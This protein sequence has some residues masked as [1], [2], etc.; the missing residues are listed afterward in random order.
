MASFKAANITT[1]ASMAG[2]KIGSWLG[3]NEPE[4]FAALTK[5]GARPDQGEHHQ[6]ELRHVGAAQGRPR[7]GPGD[8][9]QRVRAGPR[10]QEPGHRPALHSPTTST[11][12]TSTTRRSGPRCSR[13]RSSPPTSGSRPATT[14]T[15]PTKFL[16][17]LVQ[18]LDL[19]PRQRPEVRRH[20]PRQGLA[21]GRQPPGVADERDQRADLAVADRH[22][23]ARQGA[24]RPDDHDRHDVQGPQGG[25]VGRRDPDRPRRRRRSTRSAPR[26]TPRAR[27]SP[28]ARSRSRRAATSR[29]R[30][31]R[32]P[33]R[34]GRPLRFGRGAAD[35]VPSCPR[36]SV[37]RAGGHRSVVPADIGSSCPRTPVR[38]AR[39]HR[40]V[41]RFPGSL[42]SAP[43]TSTSSPAGR[44]PFW[45]TLHPWPWARLAARKGP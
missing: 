45:I 27:A 34:E 39:G 28:R 20:R 35:T 24:V 32:G 30:Q 36:T 25:P 15:S 44:D 2:K 12:S 43:P 22:R 23:P 10:G 8:D 6:A 33:A 7:C 17:A 16:Q 31:A 19:L 1:P 29:S 9:L 5:A 21:A 13:T 26:S 41:G 11:S 42:I 18:G 38:R 3:G 4:L 14:R 37:S 40:S